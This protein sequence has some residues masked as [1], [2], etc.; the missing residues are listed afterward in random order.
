M[1]AIR[2]GDDDAVILGGN[3][4]V[5]DV[6][7]TVV[8][9]LT[10]T[11]GTYPGYYTPISGWAGL[12]VGSAYS[13][14]RIINLTADTNK[15]LDDDKIAELLALFPAARQPN[16]L[17]MNR[18]SLKQLQ[19]SRTATNAT[20]APAPFPTEAFGIRIIVTDSITSTESI[21]TASS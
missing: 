3:D 21:L 16:M 13:V 20:G 10:G 6:G 14:G 8:Q 7:E 9:R 17:V 18:R 1:Y 11:N 15:G 19:Q 5:I 12:Q 2:S 4:G